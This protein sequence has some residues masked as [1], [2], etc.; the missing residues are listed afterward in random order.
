MIFIAY[1]KL[2]TYS[3]VCVMAPWIYYLSF[4]FLT[5]FAFLNMVIGIVVNTLDEQHEQERL[6]LADEKGEPSLAELKGEI[7]ALRDLIEK[8]LK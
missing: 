6:K 3:Y 4:L 5:A 2:P 8:K 7:Q 1:F